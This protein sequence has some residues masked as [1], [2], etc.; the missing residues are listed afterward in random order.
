MLYVSGR[1]DVPARNYHSSVSPKGQITLPAEVRHSLGIKPRDV[2][3]ITLEDGVIA[4]RPVQ[5]RIMKHYQRAGSLERPLDWKEVERI[6]HED[7]AESV[8]REGLTE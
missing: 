8:A 1:V 4:V 6:A 3:Q 5:S 2:V 7:Q